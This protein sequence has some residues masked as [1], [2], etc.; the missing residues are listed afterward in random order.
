MR[1]TTRLP[2]AP[3]LF[4]SLGL[5]ACVG[6]VGEEPNS[7]RDTTKEDTTDEDK[8]DV[9]CEQVTTDLVITDAADFNGL[10][11]G[12]WDLNANLAI[13]GSVVTSLVKLGDLKAVNDLTIVGTNLTTIDTKSTLKVWGSLSV[14]GNPKLTNIDK[15]SIKKWTG[16]VQ[17][18]AFQ[19]AY[20]VRNN[21][22][23]TS[24]GPLEYIPAV[25]G[26]LEIS[27]NAKL[28]SVQ[29]LTLTEAPSGIVISRNGVTSV[30]LS[31]I[32]SVADVEI[33]DNT[34]LTTLSGPATRTI[35][36]NFVV[37]GNT[38]LATLGSLTTLE[39][40]EGS[41]T[42][43]GSALANLGSLPA[44]KYVTGTV[45]VTNNA[46]LANLGSL[47]RAQLLGTTTITGNANL[48]DCLAREVA[49]CVPQV[50]TVTFDDNKPNSLDACNCYCGQ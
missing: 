46:Q 1:L 11:S 39:S 29:F 14:I 19:V 48:N 43:S 45:E 10:P 40:V 50:G 49:H 24:V 6:R 22:A 34:A 47:S 12:C 20:T 38:A 15:L 35:E 25:D 18:D 28:S 44:L 5:A 16:A 26:R 17:G 33:S 37:R 23:L 3:L 36:G 9:E 8:S 32:V 41:L 2:T 4:L 30:D 13:E 7:S 31:S 21:P 27:G 42:V